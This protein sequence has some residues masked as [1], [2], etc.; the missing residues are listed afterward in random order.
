MG[1]CDITPIVILKHQRNTLIIIDVP[2]RISVIDV[3]IITTQ[4]R[5]VDTIE[6][7]SGCMNM[8]CGGTVVMGSSEGIS[9][10]REREPAC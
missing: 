1:D 6:L 5:R 9:E 4:G 3:V 2:P 7:D 10:R 8:H